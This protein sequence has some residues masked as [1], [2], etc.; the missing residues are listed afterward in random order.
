MLQELQQC[1]QL[2]SPMDFVSVLI[3]EH[4]PQAEPKSPQDGKPQEFEL[5]IN[6]IRDILKG[7]ILVF[8]PE[9]EFSDDFG[10]WDQCKLV[11]F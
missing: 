4:K 5:N 9:L 7:V 8:H 11:R 2:L 3:Y 1:F 10:S 6:L